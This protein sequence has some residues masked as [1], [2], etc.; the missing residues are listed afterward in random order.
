[1]KKRAVDRREEATEFSDDDDYDED[2]GRRIKEGG[3]GKKGFGMNSSFLF[4]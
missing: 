4:R 1:M 3:R 2:G